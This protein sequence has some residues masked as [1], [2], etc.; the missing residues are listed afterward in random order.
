M[1]VSRWNGVDIWSRSG[2]I[3]TSGLTAAIFKYRLPL[4]S[5]INRNSSVV[6]LDPKNIDL[7]VGISLLSCLIADIYVLPV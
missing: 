6:L 5:S 3:S 2:D 7:T 1:G 4:T